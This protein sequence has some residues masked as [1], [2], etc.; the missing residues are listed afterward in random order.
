MKLIILGIDHGMQGG[1]AELGDLMTQLVKAEEVALVAEENAY[2]F[3]TV[4]RQVASEQGVPWLQI[5]MDIT[6]RLRAIGD[7]RRSLVH[8]CD[9]RIISKS[10]LT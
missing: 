1:N 7:P 2:S 8:V 10:L 9:G 4:A 6:E 5:D 3:P